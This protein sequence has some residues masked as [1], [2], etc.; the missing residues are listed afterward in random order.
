MPLSVDFNV[1]TVSALRRT[2]FLLLSGQWPPAFL[3]KPAYQNDLA[4]ANDTSQD[5]LRSVLRIQA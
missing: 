3:A 4:A 1:M 2:E 5:Y